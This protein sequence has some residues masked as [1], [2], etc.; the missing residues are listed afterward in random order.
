MDTL[1]KEII[2]VPDGTQQDSSGSHLNTQDSV[3]NKTNEIFI[4]FW[5]SYIS[6]FWINI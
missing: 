6:N 3:K 5:K 1:D 2:R 4:Y